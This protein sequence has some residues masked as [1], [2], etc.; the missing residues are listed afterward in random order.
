MLYDQAMFILAAVETYEATGDEVFREMAE[1]TIQ[2]VLRDMTSPEGA[3]YS[4][5]DADSGS[6]EGDFYIWT[7]DQVIG[8]LEEETAEQAI[9][10][11]I[12]QGKTFMTEHDTW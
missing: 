12:I 4:S 3:F 6:G 11:H 5:E 2:Y 9:D 10:R 7:I 8:L 1:S